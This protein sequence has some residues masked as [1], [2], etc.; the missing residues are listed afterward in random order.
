MT[1]PRRSLAEIDELDL[2]E[3]LLE[4]AVAGSPQT[5]F[6]SGEPG[7]GKSALLAELLRRA[8][9][10]G[11]LA[12]G[13]AP[14]SSSGSCPFGLVIDALDEYLES[15]A[16]SAFHRLGTETLSELGGVFPALRSLDS[17]SEA[18]TTA[19]ERHRAH[20]ATR[21]LLERLAV[22][23]PVVLVLDDLHWADAPRSSSRHT[24]SGAR[25]THAWCWPWA[26]ARD[27]RD[28]RSTR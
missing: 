1:W 22:K 25:P 6:V 23:Q 9:E 24:S 12:L 3:R 21:D 4:E 27:R 14:P 15:L 7:I 16:P 19:A 5:V 10:R 28:T 11:W 17:G 26:F 8:E 20:R 18:P 2:L 13:A